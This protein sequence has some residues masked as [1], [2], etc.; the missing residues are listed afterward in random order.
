[1]R[2]F[3]IERR[4]GFPGGRLCGYDSTLDGLETDV[5]VGGCGARVGFG[6]LDGDTAVGGLRLQCAGDRADVD[7]AVG[8]LDLRVAVDAA[9]ADA[10]GPGAR[11]DVTGHVLDDDRA[12]PGADVEEPVVSSVQSPA[13]TFTRVRP[14]VP[15]LR[16][17]ATAAVPSSSEPEGS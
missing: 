7:V 4:Y 11:V 12:G 3:R 2:R 6:V 8:V 14:R 10:S 5:A 13:E 15:S 16:R 9:D 1:M 17:L